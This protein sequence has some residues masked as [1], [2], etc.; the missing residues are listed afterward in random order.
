M[1]EWTLCSDK[2]P[3]QYG[4][5]IVWGPKYTRPQ[6]MECKEYFGSKCFITAKGGKANV[7]HWCELISK[8]KEEK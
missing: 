2:M 7:T 8:P 1:T 5:Y 4:F 6:I 3:R